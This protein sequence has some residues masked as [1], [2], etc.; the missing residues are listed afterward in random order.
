MFIKI[1]GIT[2]AKSGEDCFNLGADMIGLVYHRPSPRHLEA[3]QMAK[4]V[5]SLVPFRAAGKRIALVLAERNSKIVRNILVECGNSFDYVQQYECLDD[6]EIKLFKDQIHPA[7]LIQ[8]VRDWKTA[9]RLLRD[10]LAPTKTVHDEPQ[11]VLEMASGPLPGGNGLTWNW[12][13]AAS[14]CRR[15][16]TL[17]A[18]GLNPGNVRQAIRD[19]SPFGIDLSSG[20]E[21][22]PGVKDLEQVKQLIHIVR[23][24]TSF[25]Q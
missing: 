19:A 18:G 22:M 3:S 20:V 1:C 9:E 23:K 16:P 5:K 8:A 4:I 17:I 14:F 24:N 12:R 21:S 15:F 10:E 2:S 7:N 25:I 11:F 6:S 13:D